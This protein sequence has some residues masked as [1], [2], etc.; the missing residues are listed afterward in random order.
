MAR[1]DESANL[2]QWQQKRIAVFSGGLND[3]KPPFDIADNELSYVKNLQYRQ[4]FVQI[5]TGY[6]TFGQQVRGAPRAAFQFYKTDNT[7]QLT[8]ITDSTFYVWNAGEW[9]YVSDGTS[10]TA[11]VGESAGS[12]SIDVAS[13]AGFSVNDYIGIALDNGTQHQ[14][15]VTAVAAGVLTIANAIPVGRSVPVGA[16]VV[17]SVALSGS[18]DKQISIVVYTPNNWMLFTNGVD[19]PK[20]FDGVSCID[21]P[22]LPSGGNT[23]CKALGIFNNHVLLLGTSEGGTDYPQRVRWSD[24]ANPTNWSTGN[25]GYQ[26]LLSSEDYIVTGA[27]LGPYFIVYKERSLV[28]IEYVGSADRLFN[29][30]DTVAGE[31]PVSHDAVIDLGD[32]HIFIGNANVYKYRGDFSFEPLTDKFINKMFTTTSDINPAFKHRIFAIYIEELDEIWVV[33]AGGLSGQLRYILRYSLSEDSLW[34]REVSHDIIGFGFYQRISDKTWDGL[35]GTWDD[36][37]YSWDSTLLQSNSPTTLLCDPSNR[38]V[39]EYD[40]SAN[41]DAGV[42]IVYEMQTKDFEN[43]HYK[44]R[45][46]SV[47]LLLA[48]S[49]VILECSTDRGVTW[50]VLGSAISTT[51]MQQVRKWS[52]LVGD[53]IRFRLR[54]VGSGFQLGWLLFEYKLESEW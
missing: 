26:D 27:Q 23:V 5:D 25:A 9:Q 43:S 42:A 21:I 20:R 37:N 34:F 45:L 36:Q 13:E 14:T 7:S 40:Y 11:S 31:G 24:T 28:R 44:V 47:D 8:L 22:N 10:T 49:G 48:G 51:G 29:F 41:T 4:G 16:A 50:T 19:K 32:Y 33:Y 6:T 46:D 30:T 35:V 39:Y 38:V 12:T 2:E 15:Q 1:P 17:K 3:N 53:S 18:L 54:G 52:Q